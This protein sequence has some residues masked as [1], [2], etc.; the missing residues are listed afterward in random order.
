MNARYYDPKL[1]MFIQPDWF[2]MA[3]AG[4]GTNRYA[5]SGNTNSL[6]DAAKS[7]G[8]GAVSGFLGAGMAGKVAAVGRAGLGKAVGG[9]AGGAVAG[10]TS[11]V[12]DQAIQLDP[13]D[14]SLSLGAV[15]G[16]EVFNDATKGAVAGGIAGKLP[17]GESIAGAAGGLARKGKVL[18][19]IIGD[20][21]DAAKEGLIGKTLDA[22]GDE[23]DG[24][25]DER[26]D[27]DQGYNGT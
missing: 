27:E 18:G 4:V 24:N 11:S 9:A 7:F 8:V 5:Y 25:D 2:E 26:D 10:A 21:I 1:G 16:V 19:G 23:S 15:D 20:L 13:E 6:S 22:I 12:G 17:S 3:K 14:G